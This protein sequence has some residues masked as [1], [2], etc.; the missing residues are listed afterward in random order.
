MDFKAIY[1]GV[2]PG[3]FASFPGVAHFLSFEQICQYPR[4]SRK[5]TGYP[6]VLFP[7]GQPREI[8]IPWGKFITSYGRI[9]LLRKIR[10]LYRVGQANFFVKVRKFTNFYDKSTNFI[11]PTLSQNSP[12][13]RFYDFLY[14]NI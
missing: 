10:L 6:G 2:P 9:V 14:V 4:V 7:R 5:S 1:P 8:Q 3:I 12:K 13:S 11:L